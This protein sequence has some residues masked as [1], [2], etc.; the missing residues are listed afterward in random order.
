[1]SEK[2]PDNI[3]GLK[4]KYNISEEMARFHLALAKGDVTGDVR[5]MPEIDDCPTLEEQIAID[6]QE[7]TGKTDIKVG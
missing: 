6:R 4:K 3:E 7:K 5:G 1:M 2:E